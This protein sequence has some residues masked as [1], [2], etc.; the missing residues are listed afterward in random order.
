MYKVKINCTNQKLIMNS[1]HEF[2][3]LELVNE[4]YSQFMI[5]I[6]PLLIMGEKFEVTILVISESGL[7][8]FIKIN[9]SVFNLLTSK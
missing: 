6:A 4:Y 1:E 7:T 5:D 9:A 3:T 2:L 8:N